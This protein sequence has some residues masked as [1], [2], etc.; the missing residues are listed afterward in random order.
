MAFLERVKSVFGKG[1][2]TELEGEL[3]SIHSLFAFLGDI[4]VEKDLISP[5]LKDEKKID[6]LHGLERDLVSVRTFFLFEDFIVENKPLIVKRVYSKEELREDIVKNIDIKSLPLACELLF[7]DEVEQSLYFYEIFLQHFFHAVDSH[8]GRK[9]AEQILGRDSSNAGIIIEHDELD[10]DEFN[11]RV[12][13][14]D[15]KELS[16]IISIFKNLY[17]A[18][19]LEILDSEGEKNAKAL[20]SEVFRIV[21]DHYNY[22][23]ISKFLDVMPPGILESERLAFISHGELEE[24]VN[25]RTQD[26]LKEKE[27]VDLIV[28]ERTKELEDEKNKLSIVTENMFE[29][30]KLLDSNMH[31][32]FI[33]RKCREILGLSNEENNEEVIEEAFGRK[34]ENYAVEE[35]FG[36]SDRGAPFVVPEIDVDGKIY[37]LSFITLLDEKGA[38]ANFLVWIEDITEVKQLDRRKSEFISVAAHQLRTPL[39]GLKWTLGMIASGDLGPLSPDQKAFL[40]KSYDSNERMIALVNDLLN[41]NRL[42][43]QKFQYNFATADIQE[44]FD[45]V[46]FDMHHEAMR[47]DITISLEPVAEKLPPVYVDVE[48]IRQVCQNLLENSIKYTMKGGFIKIHLSK[49]GEF[50]L[51]SITDNGIGIPKDQYG[52]IFTRF[53]RGTNASKLETDGTGLGLFVV[54]NLIE[55]HGGKVWFESE[56]D[57]GTVFYFTLPIAK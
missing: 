20:A 25:Q 1:S 34:F 8:A 24:T 7:L 53:F 5:L 22:K 26:V 18:F 6:G 13:Q 51:I 33:N 15:R 37:K 57:R 46:L 43:S 14:N 50:V 19:Y 16:A 35:S 11:S 3:R 39:S 27:K 45:S 38:R 32:I 55:K 48:K 42:E 2:Q 30:A 31:L 17:T 21:S 28:Q 10:Y 56:V 9:K 44:L 36:K 54:K 41:A 40:E 4:V 49:E 29:G 47:R 23:I 12:K 52:S